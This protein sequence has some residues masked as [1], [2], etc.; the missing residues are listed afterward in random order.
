MKEEEKRGGRRRE[1]GRKRTEEAN[2]SRDA[3]GRKF[4]RAAAI[5]EMEDREGW[6]QGMNRR[7]G[8]LCGGR[9]TRGNERTNH[10]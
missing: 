3:R 9:V 2:D 6:R 4:Y 7:V 10:E 5:D 8:R 1:R